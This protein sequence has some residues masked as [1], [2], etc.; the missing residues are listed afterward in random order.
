MSNAK[1]E[2]IEEFEEM[3]HF[4]RR[5]AKVV[6]QVMAQNPRTIVI[7]WEDSVGTTVTSIPFSANLVKG[8]AD[9]LYDMVHKEPEEPD[10]DNEPLS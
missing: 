2:A 1:L 5:V 4:E 9:T 7:A 10:E 3:V 6:A 8:M